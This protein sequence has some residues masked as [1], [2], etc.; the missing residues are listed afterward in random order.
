MPLYEYYCMTCDFTFEELSALSESAKKRP[1]PE[2]GKRAPRTVSAFAIA[3]GGS[4]Q[5]AAEAAPAQQSPNTPPLCMRYSGVPLSCH[6]DEPSLK[7][8]VAHKQGRGAEY[9]DKTAM[10]AEVRKQ[11]GIPEPVYAKPS[12]GHDHDHGHSHERNPRR[13]AVTQPVANGHDHDHGHAHGSA[14]KKAHSH[15]HG[16]HAH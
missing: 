9:D 1:C 14:K 4:G 6:M 15:S 2:C 13:H 3:S 10:A 7:R 11:R 16:T 8:F 5:L 12:H